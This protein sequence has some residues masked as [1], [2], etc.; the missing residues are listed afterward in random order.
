PALV[1][2]VVDVLASEGVPFQLGLVPIYRDPSSSGEVQLSDRP[3]LVAAVEYAVRKGGAIVLHGVTHQYNGTTPDDFEFW[4]AD[5]NVK[6]PDDSVE[7]VRNKL[8]NGLDECFR[9][10]LY[11]LA[12]ETPHYAASLLDYQEIG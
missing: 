11:P 3:E 6:R 2:R 7:L 12:W 5:R 8:E 10:D 4:D 1:R 9:N